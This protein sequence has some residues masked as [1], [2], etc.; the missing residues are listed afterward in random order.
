M[1]DTRGGPRF[2]V[3]FDEAAWSQE[4]GRLAARSRSRAV[5]EAARVALERDGIGADQLARCKALAS[6]G[7]QLG[8]VASFRAAGCAVLEPFVDG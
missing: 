8:A 1:A 2:A 3:V 4:S 7:I 5:A 6:D